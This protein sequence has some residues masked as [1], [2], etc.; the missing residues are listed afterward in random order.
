MHLR[1]CVC[2][3][4]FGSKQSL[5]ES[6]LSF[7]YVGLRNQIH[8]TGLSIMLTSGMNTATT[9]ERQ[10]QMGEHPKANIQGFKKFLEFGYGGICL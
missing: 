2:V 5:R 3:C 10:P 7:H 6:L 1:V 9:P 4:V 8:L